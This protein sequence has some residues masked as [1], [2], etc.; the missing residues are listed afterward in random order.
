MEVFKITS[1][2]P[3]C[4]A[5]GHS[6][7]AGACVYSRIMDVCNINICR[8]NFSANRGMCHIVTTVKIVGTPNISVL[9]TVTDNT[10]LVCDFLMGRGISTIKIGIISSCDQKTVLYI[11]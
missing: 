6:Q 7:C 9:H 10:G 1:I 8:S 4:N 5:I 2:L 11:L 3:N